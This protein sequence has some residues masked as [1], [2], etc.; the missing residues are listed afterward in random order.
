MK[1]LLVVAGAV[2]MSCIACEN[3][4]SLEPSNEVVEERSVR[5]A[6]SA[7]GDVVPVS[8]GGGL[9]Q[10]YQGVDSAGAKVLIRELRA[11]RNNRV[12]ALYQDYGKGEW[13]KLG[14][15]V[16]EHTV[17]ETAK[18]LTQNASTT[19]KV[20]VDEVLSLVDEAADN[21]L[22]DLERDVFQAYIVEVGEG[23]RSSALDDHT[24]QFFADPAIQSRCR[25]VA[26]LG[27]QI[28]ALENVIM[29]NKLRQ[30]P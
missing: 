20:L 22:A 14:E 8:S 29:N 2:A 12:D 5:G 24:R 26:A 16:V 23:K 1:T 9:E 13:R 28:R 30:R 3:T 27:D 19:E 15:R 7:A 25:D 17:G 6:T 21:A 11:D 18:S 10:R 4:S